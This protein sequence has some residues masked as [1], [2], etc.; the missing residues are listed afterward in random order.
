VSAP[1]E[2]GARIELLYFSG[3]GGTRL[4]AE[5]LAELLSPEAEARATDIYDPAALERAAEA[6]LLVLLYPTYF[7]RPAPS[8]REFVARLG[9]FDPPKRAYLVTTYELYSEN[10]LRSCALALKARGVAVLGSGA[11]RSPGSDPTCLLPGSLVPWLYRFEGGFPRKLRRIARELAELAG[12]IAALGTGAADADRERVP[13][14]TW[15]T[16]FAQLLQVLVLNRFEG[17]RDRIRVLP[18]RC[19]LCG[20]CAACCD[21][22]AWTMAEGLPSH[23]PGRCELCTRCLHRCPGK[24]IVLIG[25]LKDNRR[26]DRRLFSVLS[27]EAREALLLEA[28]E[29][30][31]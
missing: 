18:E 28:K 6:D 4:A 14:P 2:P 23:D 11:L 5:L 19:S 30:G 7:L 31:S 1:T 9:P 25:A 8:M 15:Y 10:S 24:A 3:T 12:E 17:W 20:A 16:P 29:G 13:A 26:L 22:G 27:R 21:R